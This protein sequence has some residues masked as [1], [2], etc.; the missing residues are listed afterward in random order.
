MTNTTRLKLVQAG[1]KPDC[2]EIDW[3]RAI[4]LVLVAIAFAAL[5]VIAYALNRYYEY[6]HRVSADKLHENLPLARALHDAKATLPDDV[7]S[8]HCYFRPWG[9]WGESGMA[10]VQCDVSLKGRAVRDMGRNETVWLDDVCK[11]PNEPG[12]PLR[13]FDRDTDAMLATD[14]NFLIA[15][16]S[17]GGLTVQSNVDK[18]KLSFEQ[19]TGIVVAT[20]QVFRASLTDILAKASRNAPDSVKQTWQH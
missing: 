1:Q 16:G 8:A 9:R 6:D 3:S 14:F 10:H 4:L 15:R 19:A 5:A 7:S 11:N 12:H 18:S 2:K 20:V 17:D 13:G